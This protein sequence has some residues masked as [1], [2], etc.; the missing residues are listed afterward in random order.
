M[1]MK[2]ANGKRAQD[3]TTDKQVLKTLTGLKDIAL[4]NA[5]KEG[6]LVGVNHWLQQ[7]ADP[8]SMHEFGYKIS[9][10]L[11][12][13]KGTEP[14]WFESCSYAQESTALDLAIR[15]LGC[16]HANTLSIVETLLKNGANPNIV[17]DFQNPLLHETI[18]YY[19]KGFTNYEDHITAF[20]EL[21]RL[22]CVYGADTAKRNIVYRNENGFTPLELAIAVA[23]HEKV[24]ILLQQGADPN[25]KDSD[26]QTSLHW[27]AI[28]SNVYGDELHKYSFFS[29]IS[30]KNVAYPKIFSTLANVLI[31]SGADPTVVDNK[32]KTAASLVTNYSVKMALSAPSVEPLERQNE[33]SC[34]LL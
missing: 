17:S 31:S 32:G 5:V 25:L 1:D 28:Y 8:N 22:L 16:L 14:M 33:E 18:V 26:G 12:F 20:T 3:L 29:D 6:D 15:E 9:C 10:P 13:S 2:D 34:L 23:D 30:D 21:T 11:A 24:G 7:G 19:S 27:V 4:F